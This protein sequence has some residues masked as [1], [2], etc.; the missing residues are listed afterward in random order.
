MKL[1]NEQIGI[2]LFDK[3]EEEIEEPKSEE[4]TETPDDLSEVVGWAKA[5]AA[6][7]GVSQAEAL[8]LAEKGMVK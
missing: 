8:R 7:F 2:S 5:I 1:K 4:T 6:H 3:C